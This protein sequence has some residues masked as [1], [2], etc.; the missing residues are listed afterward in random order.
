MRDPESPSPTSIGPFLIRRR[1]GAGG[2]AETF[3]GVRDGPAGFR[4]RVCLKRVLPA[5]SGDQEL[6]R[7]FLREARLA[8][9]LRHRNITQVVELG[10]DSGVYYLALELVEGVD[11]RTLLRRLP[12]RRLPVQLA[13]LVGREIAEALEHAHARGVVHRDVSPQNIMVSVDGEVKLTDFGISKALDD[14]RMTRSDMVRGNIWYMAPE[15]LERG[16]VATPRSDLFSLGLVLFECLSGQRP[17]P[18]SSLSAATLS[19]ATGAITPL[20]ELAPE[21]SEPVLMLVERL[22]AFAP[23]DRYPEARAVVDS[24]D[25][26]TRAGAARRALA[27]LVRDVDRR[28]PEPQPEP[29][30]EPMH[31]PMDTTEPQRGRPPSAASS[32]GAPKPAGVRVRD[33]WKKYAVAPRVWAST[34]RAAFLRAQSRRAPQQASTQN[35]AALPPAW[36]SPVWI[37]ALAL[38]VFCLGALALSLALMLS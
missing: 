11:L 21:L 9:S 1:I 29:P 16:A 4:Q 22:T 5:L 13:I 8:A 27:E 12:D 28:A 23:D 25:P 6:R 18:A 17:Y 36:K 31:R 2:M 14:L 35:N 30:D 37:A 20:R 32:P 7:L 24:L 26:L 10:E 3:E 34:T 19:V 38:F 33:R 15:M